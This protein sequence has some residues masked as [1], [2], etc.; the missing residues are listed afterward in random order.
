MR[1]GVGRPLDALC[2]NRVAELLE[3]TREDILQGL[4]GN[5]LDVDKAI[6]RFGFTGHMAS[7]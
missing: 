3:A 1:L 2:G 6:L 7:H 5:T 4:V